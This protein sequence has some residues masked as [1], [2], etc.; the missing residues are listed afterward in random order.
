MDF[1]I[2]WTETAASDLKDIVK[3]IAI[4]K[5]NTA[6]KIGFAII[7]KIQSLKDNPFLG[8]K[9]PEKDDDIIREVILS[10]Y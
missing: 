2:I 3:Y 8:R 1:K 5:P 4:D 7:E 10:P 6:Q 9:V